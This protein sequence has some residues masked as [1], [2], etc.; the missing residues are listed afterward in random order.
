MIEKIKKIREI[1]KLSL[2][3]CKKALEKA[4]GS[5]DDALILL[6]G[7]QAKKLDKVIDRQAFEGRITSYI[8]TGSQVACMVE[9]NCETDFAARSDL[10]IKFCEDIAMH[11]VAM[12]PVYI[13]KDEVSKE[14]EDAQ[15]KVIR[16]RLAEHY[17]GKTEEYKDENSRNKLRNWYREAV[18]MEQ[19]SIIDQSKTITELIEKLSAQLGEKI[20]ISRF[21]RWSV[22]SQIP[23]DS[24][25]N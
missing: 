16:D 13:S 25:T 9:I 11:I 17:E 1:T 12:H 18:L 20:V 8:H 24:G 5:I 14:Q 3:E 19:T 7:V 2:N 21:E 6:Q 22:G 4:G 23:T 15:K 10:F